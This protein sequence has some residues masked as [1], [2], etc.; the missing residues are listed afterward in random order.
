MN[1]DDKHLFEAYMHKKKGENWEGF[2]SV[3]NSDRTYE[4]PQLDWF[5][6]KVKDYANESGSKDLTNE[7]MLDALKRAITGT[8]PRFFE[9]TLHSE[10]M[11]TRSKAN[12]KRKF[13][14]QGYYP[15]DDKMDWDYMRH[16]LQREIMGEFIRKKPYTIYLPR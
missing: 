15:K 9:Q 5:K 10:L 6:S 8:H 3:E 16:W 13:R 14:D 1:Q 7:Q 4:E 11:K 12:R 2:A